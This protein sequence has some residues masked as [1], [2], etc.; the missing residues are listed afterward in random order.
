[1][2]NGRYGGKRG[3]RRA[4]TELRLL[5]RLR[6]CDLHGRT[7]GFGVGSATVDRPITISSAAR[8]I[9]A[10]VTALSLHG[11]GGV[12][13]WLREAAGRTTAGAPTTSSAPRSYIVPSR[14]ATV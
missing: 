1:M 11:V 3:L 4:A 6:R 13:R 9:S 2:A 14:T 7:K 5:I 10:V 8:A 12:V